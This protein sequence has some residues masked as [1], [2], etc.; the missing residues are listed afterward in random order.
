MAIDIIHETFPG[1]QVE[2]ERTPRVANP[3]M[4]IDETTS[5]DEIASFT[6]KDMSDHFRGPGVGLLKKNLVQYKSDNS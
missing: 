1:S 6:Q 5:G 4:V 2:W 3:I